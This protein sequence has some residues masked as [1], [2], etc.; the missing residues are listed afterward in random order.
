GTAAMRHGRGVESDPCRLAADEFF[1]L[2]DNSPNSA[3]SRRWDHEPVV[4]RDHLIG[5]AFFVYWPSA[6]PA[7]GL[8]IR[9]VPTVSEFR[10][11]R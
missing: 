4:S 7:P 3:D 10:F 8:P 9:I 11:I 2:G 6:G 1:V 5:K